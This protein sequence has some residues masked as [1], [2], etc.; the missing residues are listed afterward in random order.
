MANAM[1]M[2][3]ELLQQGLKAPNAGRIDHSLTERGVGA[4]GGILEE[5]LGSL[6]GAAGTAAAP[7]RGTESAGG[8]LDQ[9]KQMAG[10]VLSDPK[11]MKAGGIG[12][13]AGALLGGGTKSV[14]GSL[15]GGAMALLGMLALQA[16]RNAGAKQGQSLDSQT[17]LAAG[18]RAPENVEEEREVESLAELTVKAMINAA[19][20]DGRIDEAEL[21]R[22]TGQFG[23]L[24]AKEREFLLNELRKPLDTDA[25]VRAV[26]NQQVAAQVYAASLLATGNDSPAEQRYMA[27]LAGKLGL[28]SK[29]TQYLQRAVGVAA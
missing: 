11:M 10:P 24:D 13:I 15:G 5:I 4:K 18:L 26:P 8:L 22:I 23:E 17:K 27:E 12:A 9:L 7:S 2:L 6:T 1:D 29:L 3:G 28:D 21:K 25:I 19:K 20:S 16:F 14:K